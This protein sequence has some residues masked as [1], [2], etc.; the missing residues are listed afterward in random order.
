MFIRRVLKL[1]EK[2]TRVS[3]IVCT[4]KCFWSVYSAVTMVNLMNASKRNQ[5]RDSISIWIFDRWQPCVLS[6]IHVAH[7]YNGIASIISRIFH[8][9][10]CI[11]VSSQIDAH[12]DR[13]D[14]RR[15]LCSSTI[16]IIKHTLIVTPTQKT[17]KQIHC[18]SPHDNHVISLLF[19]TADK[20]M[21][22]IIL[23]C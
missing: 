16:R 23:A 12:D 14:E 10:H 13:L 5:C 11:F 2:E 18:N 22:V 7:V 3:H 17:Y 8:V 15:Q 20:S 9:F 4:D 21:H 1:E 6:T 19:C